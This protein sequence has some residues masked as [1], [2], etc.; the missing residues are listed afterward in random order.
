MKR[1]NVIDIAVLGIIIIIQTVLSK[2]HNVS[3]Y[4]CP[5][6]CA[7]V[8]AA[9]N[10]LSCTIAQLLVPHIV[11]NSARPNVSQFSLVEAGLRQISS[12]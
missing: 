6:S 4:T 7:M 1:Y 12:L 3:T 11:P 9:L 2:N 8:N 10:P 5:N